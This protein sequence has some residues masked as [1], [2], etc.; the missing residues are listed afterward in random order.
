[1]SWHGG[2][3][4]LLAL[5]VLVGGFAGPVGAAAPVDTSAGHRGPSLA[6]GPVAPATHAPPDPE[7]DVIGWEAG[8][9]HNESIDVDQSDGLSDAELDAYV[10]RSMAR[11]EVI[12][13][14]EFLE[15]VPVE[16][17]SRATYRNQTLNRTHGANFTAWNNQVWEALFIVGEQSDVQGEL[18]TV[19]GTSV[20]GFYSPSD[21]EIK[22]ITDTPDEPVLNNATLVHELVHA[23][24]DQYHNLSQSKYQGETQ[25]TQLAVDGLIEGEANYIERQ[26]SQRCGAEWECVASPGSGSGGSGP[27]PNLGI[28][29]TLL[30]P[31]SDGPVY[32]NYLLNQA[33]W[34]AVDAAFADPPASTEQVIHTT[35]E[36]P[37][38][39]E[40][41]DTATNGWTPFPGQGINGSDTVGEA[42]LYAMFWY[43]AREYDAETIDPNSLFRGLENEFD[44]YNYDVSPSAGWGNDRVFPYRKR[45][46]DETQYGY[47]WVTEWDTVVDADEFRQTYRRILATHGAEQVGQRTWVIESGPFADSF[48]VVQEGTRVTIVNAPETA[49]LADIRPD[50]EH[51][52][53]ETPTRTASPSPPPPTTEQVETPM[54]VATTTT[55]PGQPGFGALAA[56]AAVLV[57]LLGRRRRL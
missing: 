55:A 47:V 56:L 42:S 41:E 33:G 35:D 32:V 16:V 2:G 11:V 37:V 48:R 14:R 57:A 26:Y 44:T 34:S 30:N 1:M 7:S 17:I 29:L 28:L 45:V 43:Q 39:I 3:P 36:A 53:L 46:G 4:V 6:G 31:Y 20:L 50:I 9:W 27:Q 18:E 24:Q 10:A 5:L 40:F 51:R 22:V 15:P 54:P 19:Y 8:Y 38:P 21:D 52:P 23:M 25:D 12:R 49:D 13:E